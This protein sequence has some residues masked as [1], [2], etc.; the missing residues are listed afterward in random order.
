MV[1]IALLVL[2]AV[3]GRAEGAAQ[4]LR[5]VVAYPEVNLPSGTRM[6]LRGDSLGLSWDTS[7][8]MDHVGEN[9]WVVDVVVDAAP[10]SG[11]AEMKPILDD[12][13]WCKGQ[14]QMVNVSAMD[15]TATVTLFP[16]FQSSSDL[17]ILE[18]VYSPQL[19]NVRDI[20]VYVPAPAMENP[21]RPFGG[22]DMLVAHDGQNL[23]NASTSAF[24]TAWM[25]QNTADP[26][27]D[28]G[29]TRPYFVIGVYNTANRTYEY[30]PQPDPTVGT[31]GGAD[32]LLDFYEETV[33]PLVAARF[34]LLPPPARGSPQPSGGTPDTR[35][36]ML[37]SSLGGLLSCYAAWTRPGVYAQAGCMS[38]SF[39]WADE[40]FNNVTLQKPPPTGKA[41]P[42]VNWYVDSGDSGPDN[43]DEAQTERVHQ[44]LI[45]LGYTDSPSRAA[46]FAATDSPGKVWHYVQ[47]GGQ[48]NEK[49]WGERF[50]VGE[51][52]LLGPQVVE[53][54]PL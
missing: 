36:T 27:I 3:W 16:W 49:Y 39:W 34:G 1:A 35:W 44:H 26:D 10:P 13:V 41:N 38:S 43:D 19:D 2:A 54:V 47:A 52:L 11:I 40:H 42:E 24:G 48:H 8:A 33:Y 28:E 4:T 51:R 6:G 20:I 29:N 32:L 37:G 7:L 30:T 14:N 5:V 45:R 18:N 25:I 9:Q 23:F 17:V 12:Q 22:G 53:P 50:H 15:S 46:S 31:G 21:L